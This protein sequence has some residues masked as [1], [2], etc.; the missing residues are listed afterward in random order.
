MTVG[1]DSGQTPLTTP[2]VSARRGA[3][4]YA[5]AARTVASASSAGTAASSPSD[6]ASA[7][8]AARVTSTRVGLNLGKFQLDYTSREM[9]VD[10]AEAVRGGLRDSN[11]SF[12]EELE[13]ARVQQS[14]QATRTATAPKADAA[15]TA[16]P[17]RAALAYAKAQ[18]LDTPAAALYSLGQI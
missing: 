10:L 15:P 17:R 14:A 18:G 3:R 4:S 11:A 6:T 16:T 2:G 12:A 13:L 7:A 1:F 9:T 5:R 8:Q